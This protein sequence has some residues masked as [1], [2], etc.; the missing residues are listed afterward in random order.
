MKLIY[1]APILLAWLM[2][3]AVSC[4]KHKDDFEEKIPVA[5]INFESPSMSSTYH[6]ADSIAI[7]ATAIS[8]ASIH[9]Y[10]IVIRKANDT[11]KLFFQHVH[12][13]NDTLYINKKWKSSVLSS[14]NMEA[15]VVVYLDHDSNTLS[16]K[17]LFK[18]Q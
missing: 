14:A 10:D 12:E 1:S 18:I 9:G 13:H 15:Q 17:A 6:A 3:T 5:S 11:T 8:T 2:I 7:K 4:T 16:K